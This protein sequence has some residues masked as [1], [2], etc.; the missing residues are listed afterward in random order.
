MTAQTKGHGLGLSIVENMV[1][2]NGGTISVNSEPGKGSEF[3]IVFHALFNQQQ[4]ENVTDQTN[5]SNK[6]AEVT[7]ETYG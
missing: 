4:K 3:T 6:I 7:L 5:D 1:H 2:L